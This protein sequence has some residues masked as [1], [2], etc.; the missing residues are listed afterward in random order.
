MSACHGCVYVCECMCMP[1]AC[2]GS[3]NGQIQL[4]AMITASLHAR[5]SFHH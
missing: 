3:P 1:V 2:R 4:L 5:E